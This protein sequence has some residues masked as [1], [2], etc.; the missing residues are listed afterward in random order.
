MFSLER[1]AFLLAKLPNKQYL[2][3]LFLILLLWAFNMPEVQ[4]AE[5]VSVWYRWE[6]T[7]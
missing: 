7:S 1:I 5:R 3:S 6:Q 4:T 2:L